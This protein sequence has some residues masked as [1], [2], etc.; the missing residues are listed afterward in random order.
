ME[1]N[2]N[3]KGWFSWGSF[4]LQLRARKYKNE[5]TI[6]LPYEFG[7]T[8]ELAVENLK[9]YVKRVYGDNYRFIEQP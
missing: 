1:I 7:Q 5:K 2:P 8:E 6:P 3:G 4:R 9:K